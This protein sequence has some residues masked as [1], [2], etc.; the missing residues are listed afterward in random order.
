MQVSKMLLTSN[1]QSIPR[2]IQDI[3]YAYEMSKTLTKELNT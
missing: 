1:V 2:K 3:Y